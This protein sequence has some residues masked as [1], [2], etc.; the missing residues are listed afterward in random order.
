MQ[1]ELGL[2]FSY[3][4]LQESAMAEFSMEYQLERSSSEL[5]DLVWKIAE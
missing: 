5:P 4:S 1:D 2:S 3:Q